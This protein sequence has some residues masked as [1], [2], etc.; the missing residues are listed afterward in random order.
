MYTLNFAPPPDTNKQYDMTDD[1]DEEEPKIA[2][3]SSDNDWEEATEIKNRSKP[4]VLKKK[5]SNELTYLDL[6]HSEV[7]EDEDHQA[8]NASGKIKRFFFC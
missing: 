1:D 2:N 3:S 6:T 5:T 8:P 7:I 4:S